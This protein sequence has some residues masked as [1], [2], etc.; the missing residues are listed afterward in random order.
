MILVA[1]LSEFLATDLQVQVRLPALPDFLRSRGSRTESTQPERKSL[2][3]RDYG[4]WRFAALTTRHPSIRK[5]WHYRRQVA[6]V[7]RS[8]QFARALR[9][10]SSFSGKTGQRLQRV[11]KLRN[12]ATAIWVIRLA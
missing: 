4:L 6:A 7:A 2:E 11:A 12:G 8:V 3:N 1:G 5:S 9:P 10:R